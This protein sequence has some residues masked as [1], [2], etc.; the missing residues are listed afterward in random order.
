MQNSG[1]VGA[2]IRLC[3]QIYLGFQQVYNILERILLA[4]TSGG[5]AGTCD[6]FSMGWEGKACGPR[7][8]IADSSNQNKKKYDCF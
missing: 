3:P 2:R 5:A 7:M 1:I 8:L 4:A 6:E